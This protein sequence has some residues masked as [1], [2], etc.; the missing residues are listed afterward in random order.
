[1]LAVERK[2]VSQNSPQNWMEST[3]PSLTWDAARL[4]RLRRRL[5]GDADDGSRCQRLRRRQCRSG[6]KRIGLR[7][8][9]PRRAADPNT[10]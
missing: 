8:E 7:G 1:M 3:M 2:R 10:V 6:W 5:V 9:E 4:V